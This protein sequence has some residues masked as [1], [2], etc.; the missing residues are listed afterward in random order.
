MNRTIYKYDANGKQIEGIR[1]NSDGAVSME[2]VNKYNASGTLIEIEH[3]CTDGSLSS[4]INFID[5]IKKSRKKDEM[6]NTIEEARFDE[7]GNL[8]RISTSAYTYY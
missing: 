5:D 4:K 2:E 7:K 3:Y 6:G 8:T 1:H